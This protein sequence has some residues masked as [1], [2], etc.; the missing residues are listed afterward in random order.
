MITPDLTHFA[1]AAAGAVLCAAVLWA[2][3]GAPR[4]RSAADGAAEASVERRVRALRDLI[5]RFKLTANGAG[6]SVWEW[7]LRDQV[8][9]DARMINPEIYGSLTELVDRRQFLNETLH[10]EDRRAFIEAM[11]RVFQSSCEQFT[12]RYRVRRP[13]GGVSYMQ[14]HGRAFRDEN[15]KA[16]RLFALNLDVTE[17]TLVAAKLD[18]QTQSQNELLRHLQLAN[19]TAGVGAWKWDIVAD[20]FTPDVFIAQA[21]SL[22]E[23]DIGDARAFFVSSVHPDDRAQFERELD[24][25]LASGRTYSA[26]HRILLPAGATRHVQAYAHIERDD[27]G[28]AVRMLGVTMDVTA[29]MLRTEQ[30]E[31]QAAEERALK[32]QLRTQAAHV[33]ALLDRNNVA[34]QAAGLYTWEADARTRRLVWVGNRFKA[35]G[36][37]ALP[38]SIEDYEDA[39][40]ALIHPEDLPLVQAEADRAY[41]NGSQT[42][43]CRFRM[44][45]DGLTRH[46]H[47]YAHVVR[48]ERGEAVRLLGATADVTNEVQTTAL[49]QRQAAQERQLI[50][51]LNIAT[52]AAGISSWEIDLA[53]RS[54]LWI[55][56]PIKGVS[57]LLGPLDEGSLER[58]LERVVPEDR[59][60]FA[61][62]LADAIRDK[63]DRYAYRYRVRLD[64]GSLVHVQNHN[65][66]LFDDAGRATR[67][68]GVSWDVTREIEAAEQLER[69][70][71]EQQTLLERLSLST[72]AAGISSWEVDVEAGRFV[73]ADDS[74]HA[75]HGMARFTGTTE[76]FFS[77]IHPDD[78]AIFI[79]E[80]RESM[81]TRRDRFSCRYRL[82]RESAPTL[83]IQTHVRVV[84]D[85]SGRPRRLLGVS[86]DIT[87]EI[88]AAERLQQQ[89]A[90]LRD[91]ERRLE[92]A[93][94]SSSE[95]HW[96]AD[97]DGHQIWFSSSYNALVGWADGEL[98][99]TIAE[100]GKFVHRK[101][102]AR[103]SRCSGDTS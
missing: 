69:Q 66:L 72:E 100:F 98:P 67:V 61:H 80:M 96:E 65:R 78:R 53:T 24:A 4:A 92:R 47:A 20:R 89:A 48:D 29:E 36:L 21:L 62:R 101:I 43:S 95:G 2:R 12:H 70:A 71:R 39:V 37:D 45:R 64:D 23:A 26:R 7:D 38:L 86:W 83:H 22:S 87:K 94:L 31:R 76:N 57:E 46:M 9:T 93:S 50:E 5:E 49:L 27:A 63:Q 11:E 13:A 44:T 18:E 15:G 33:H 28:A 77:Y 6:I 75:L 8:R 81:Q 103:D 68:L 54:F 25:A 40:L 34:T 84:F 1:S 82:P 41:A 10:P 16:L 88:E 97:I 60:Q 42:Y 73:N 56:N 35:F 58:L 3:R 91:A 51:R 79:E 74:I 85:D 90:Q 14:L 59:A 17:Q 102:W 52:Q 19:R 55:E 30:F 32:D 99:N